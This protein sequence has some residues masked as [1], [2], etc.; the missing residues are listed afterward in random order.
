MTRR[1]LVETRSAIPRQWSQG[2]APP[3]LERVER[4][5]DFKDIV[6]ASLSDLSSQYDAEVRMLESSSDGPI[7]Q[8]I[9]RTTIRVR[10][11]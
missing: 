11:P 7:R 2:A 3:C 5:V 8:R 1:G 10:T 9:E 4:S 6:I